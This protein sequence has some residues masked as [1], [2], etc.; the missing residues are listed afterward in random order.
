VL[1]G[2][3][4]SQEPDET[5]EPAPPPAPVDRDSDRDGVPDSRD[6]CASEAEDTDGFDDEDG[7]PDA[8]N[9][10]DGI[11][12][13]ADGCTGEAEDKDTFQDDDGCPDTD[14]DGDGVLD[15]SDRCP[16]EAGTSD[17]D[18]CPAPAAPAAAPEPASEPIELTQI[19]R[20]EKNQSAVAGSYD[21][22]LDEIAK[23]LADHPEI[24]LVAIEGHA[25][26]RGSP[27]LNDRLSRAR[28][29]AVRTALV[30][31]GVAK[32]RLTAQGFGTARPV[33]SN[34]T[35]DSRAQNRRVELRIDKRS[36]PKS[37]P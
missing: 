33:A 8:D 9:D 1:A 24:E 20:F 34:D 11:A 6:Q 21:G 3:S 25:D 26:D 5:R 30:K 12:D 7:C 29:E 31:R 36:E 18:G 28:A 27:E 35:E 14:N 16:L 2:V 32:K 4:Y 22:A 13:T 37:A 10:G 17:G 23:Q 19:I 15:A